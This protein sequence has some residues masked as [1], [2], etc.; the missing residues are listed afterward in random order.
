MH[1]FL[2]R[3]AFLPPLRYYISKIGKNRFLRM[4]ILLTN[5]DGIAA[6]GMEALVKAL[7]EEH[8]VM[9]SAPDRQ[10]SATSRSLTCMDALYA[11]RHTYAFAPEVEAYAVSGTP[12]DCARLGE[13]NLFDG[14]ADILLSGINDGGNLGTDVLY[15][16]TC[17]AAQEAA[18][19]GMNAVAVSLLWDPL[20]PRHFDTAVEIAKYALAYAMKNPLPFGLFYNVNVPN[21]PMDKIKGIKH[22]PLGMVLYPRGYEEHA[23]EEGRRVFT[24][25]PG[26]P[27]P[28]DM[29][30][31]TDARWI[32]EGYVTVTVLGYDCGVCMSKQITEEEFLAEQL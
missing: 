30:A 9:V 18:L 4:N 1:F 25:V 5:D 10:R 6:P 21:L 7:H 14:Q 2:C 20:L 16:G 26:G 19:Q 8:K 15:S 28:T 17:G 13:S 22:C 31:Y 27:L 32:R 11:K 3:L 23:E 29:D 24:M 12:A